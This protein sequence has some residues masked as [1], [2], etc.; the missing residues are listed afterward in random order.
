MKEVGVLVLGGLGALLAIFLKEAVQQA[1]QRRVLAWQ[2]F[3]YLLAWKSNIV[4]SPVLLG[5]Y[6]KVEERDKRLTAS[7]AEGTSAFEAQWKRH[8]AEGAE[9][10]GWIKEAVQQAMSKDRDFR[11]DEATAELLEHGLAALAQRQTWLVDSKSFVS[12]KDAAMLGRA[13]ALNVIQFRTSMLDAVAALQAIGLF[14][15]STAEH[16]TSA[17]ANMIDEVVIHGESAL[18]AFIRLERQVAQIS[19]QSV[20]QLVWD[21]LVAK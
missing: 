12:D 18:V 6:M 1:L 11:L 20:A 8:S 17:I 13:I 21:I 10:R 16:R 5:I 3:G 2:L 7:M 15:K 14:S 9:T 19:K 4:R